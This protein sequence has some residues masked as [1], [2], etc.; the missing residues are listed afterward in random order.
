MKPAFAIFV[1]GML[2]IKPVLA[3]KAD[4]DQPVHLESDRATV[5]EANKLATF[6]GNV[7]L[8][9]G[10]LII[11]AD[12]M[13]VKEDANGF[14]HAT[15][16]GNLASFRQK[17]DGKD[18]YVEGWSE[19]MEYASKAEKV[20]LVQKARLRRGQDE[21]YGDY[22]SYDAINEFFQLIGGN[23]ETTAPT[24]SSE[25]RVRAVI[26]PKKK[27]QNPNAEAR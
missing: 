15:A 2:F 3:E 27:E 6:T 4:K 7:V 19:R 16:F 21:V 20:E 23:N 9:Q 11:R 24:R 8:T 26:Q 10:T 18:E 14:Q 22:I 1:I 12:K 25:G 17:R 13:T 5:Q